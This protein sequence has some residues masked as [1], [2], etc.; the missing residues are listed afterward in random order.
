V[1]GKLVIETGDIS[2]KIRE[3]AAMT[4]LIVLKIEHPPSGG[5]ATFTSPFR[6]LIADSSTPVLGVP[7][8]A[9]TFERALL[10]YDGSPFAKE[11][12]F[13]ATYFAE[14]WKTE[15]VVYTALDSS[16][17][18]ADVQDHVRRYLD[19]HEVEA[20]YVVSEHGVTE[21]L[22]KTVAE[23]NIDLLLTGSYGTS[24]V[25]QVLSGSALDYLLRESQIPIFICH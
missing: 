9:R 3:R 20:D 21:D 1:T 12:L 19:I 11:A 15:L 6:S 18:Q 16:R 25:R 23:L 8:N 4:D 22:T 7:E 2:R 24:V 10:A 17:V 14:T 5:L 13:V